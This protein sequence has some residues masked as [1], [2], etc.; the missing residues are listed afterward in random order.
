MKSVLQACPGVLSKKQ[1]D[2]L[3]ADGAIED[4]SGSL[5]AGPSSVDLTLSKKAW[6]LKA[7]QRPSTRELSKIRSSGEE[8]LAQTD[9][10]GDFFHFEAK[11]IYLVQLNET[12]GLPSNVSGRSTGKS[13]VGRLDVITR[14]ITTNGSE[15]DVVREGYEG[16]LYLMLLPQTFDIRV[17]LG[18]S[19]NQLRLFS[20]PQHAAVVSR[21]MAGYY[22]SPFWYLRKETEY[23][24]GEVLKKEADSLTVDPLLFD[25]TVDLADPDSAFIY[26]AKRGNFPP[27]DFGKRAGSKKISPGGFF[28]RVPVEKNKNESSVV[29]KTGS[30]YIMKSRER[31]YIPEDVAVEVVAISERIG[32]IRIHYAGF[33]HPGFGMDRSDGKCGTPLIFEVRATDMDTKLYHE[34]ILARIQL[35]KMSERTQREK[36]SYDAQELKL[37]SVFGEWPEDER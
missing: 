24:E 18:D 1:L 9:S 29:L 17:A 15:Y 28:E 23:V 27:I 31:L 7:G 26:G 37:S 30:F 19:L 22:G 2:T 6:K 10:K 8:F 13:S 5:R 14:L 11:Q 32:D 16:D 35:S 33:A 21:E 34:S 36:S 12:L 25:L 20:G 3:I 4:V